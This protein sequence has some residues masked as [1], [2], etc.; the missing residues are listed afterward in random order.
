[1]QEASILIIDDNPGV[2]SAGKLFLKRHFPVVETARDPEEIPGLLRERHYDLVLLDMNFNRS[3][4]TG[5]EGFFWLEKIRELDPSA[6]VVLIT[7]YGDVELAVR[8]IK[9]GATDFVLKPW[10]N[11]K[12]LATLLSAL[13]LKNSQE[14]NDQLKTRQAGRNLAQARDLPEIVGTS[15]AMQ[16]VFDT[17]KRVAETDANVLL[18]GENGTGKDLVAQAIHGQSK[19][20]QENFV[21]VDLGALTESLFESELFG[22]VKGAFTDARED[23]PGRFEAADG[24]TIF[25][26]EIGNLTLGLQAKLLTV[27]Q[28]RTVTRVGANRS[29]PV[30]VRVIAA[31][32][33]NLYEAV[34]N[35][36]FR[37]D[38]LYRINT[39]EIQLPP[40]RERAADI[41]ALALHF[42]RD[43]ARK[44]GRPVRSLSP[45]LL[46]EMQRY[47]WPGNIRELQ[48]AVERAVI[49]C[50][51]D[52]L[53]PEDFFFR[54]T[55]GDAAEIATMNLEEVEKQL[56]V[57]ALN[58]HYGNITEAAQE[59][60][61]TRAS[62]YRRLE[63][64]NL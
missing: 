36:V 24:G 51:G 10:D 39:I 19:R 37:Q 40:L 2:L 33:Q 31:T 47:A 22:H 20:A 21:K 6:C 11:E 54:Q 44:Y 64:Y 59:L 53:R 42:L 55:G 30:N 12:L 62:L 28:N 45:A 1:M 60:G 27:L 25:L 7:A 38:L 4:N 14:E 61:L 34:K 3:K 13:R 41:E 63:K 15:P 57:K 18:L 48:H 17:I 8:A 58:K 9:Q 5:Q 26:D 43:F 49:M 29:R 56:I 32:N 50:P 35:R 16:Q 46:R 52:V 23:R